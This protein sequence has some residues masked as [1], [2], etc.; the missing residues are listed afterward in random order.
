MWIELIL[1]LFPILLGKL[2][3]SGNQTWV[4][5]RHFLKNEQIEP[6][7]RANNWQYMSL[8]KSELSRKNGKSVSATVNLIVY[9]YLKTFEILLVMMLTIMIFLTLCDE[10]S[11][12]VEDLHNSVN[13]Q[14]P[15]WPVYNIL[16]MYEQKVH[17]VDQ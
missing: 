2:T 9:Q 3:N 14:S 5:G 12:Q 15:K 7:F 4:C 11:Q 6:V 13:Q 16:I 10:M 1:F 8:I 17:L